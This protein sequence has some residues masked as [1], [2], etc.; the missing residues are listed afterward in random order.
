MPRISFPRLPHL[1]VPG[2][3]IYESPAGEYSTLTS[4]TGGG[5]DRALRGGGR[6]HFDAAGRHT[7]TEDANGNRTTFVYDGA[8]ERVK[9][10][11]IEATGV[12]WRFH[13]DAGGVLDSIV[14]PA[15]RVASFDKSTGGRIIRLYHPD[16]SS[17]RLSYAS[18]RYVPA[19]VANEVD[20]AD[21]IYYDGLSRPYRVRRPYNS[22]SLSP[23][24]PNVYVRSAT[25]EGVSMGNGSPAGAI[26]AQ[27]L[28]A[29]A[30]TFTDPRNNATVFRTNVFGEPTYV[31]DALGRET[32]ILRN[33]SSEPYRVQYPNGRVVRLFWDEGRLMQFWDSTYATNH[34]LPGE[35]K[36]DFYYEDPNCPH[37]LTRVVRWTSAT[38]SLTSTYGYDAGVDPFDGCRLASATDERGHVTEFSYLSDGRV[39]RVTEKAIPA[40]IGRSRDGTTQFFYYSASHTNAGSRGNLD[41]LVTIHP[42]YTAGRTFW[43]G[44]TV[45]PQDSLVATH[46]GYD[47]YGNADYQRDPEGHEVW[48][49]FDAMNQPREVAVEA[50]ASS[51]SFDIIHAFN[52]D[53]AGR[54]TH[55]YQ[56]YY[57]MDGPDSTI[58][59]RFEYS[60]LGLLFRE[61]SESRDTTMYL[62]DVA[63]NVQRKRSGNGHSSDFQH[64]ALNRVWREVISESTQ[65]Y[66]S[67]GLTG[68]IPTRTLPA[69]TVTWHYDVSGQVDT[70]TNR[71]GYVIRD[72][73]LDGSPRTERQSIAGTEHT[74]SYEYDLLGRRT[75]LNH[76]VSLKNQF[77][78]RETHYIYIRPQNQSCP[79]RDRLSLFRQALGELPR[80]YDV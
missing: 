68:I 17:W 65:P 11:M 73:Y 58:S 62:Y 77:G 45:Q 18:G 40:A 55:V 80:R 50:D 3:G 26:Q 12:K 48:R 59:R 47:S 33:G 76:P 64:D 67:E 16:N 66:A 74:L 36:T 14:D 9:E 60:S 21:S 61:I 71:H 6:V 15:G 32:N 44:W 19:G 1:R 2:G 78:T 72:Y 46:L 41:S 75:T 52:Y 53:A 56:P 31:R 28:D 8:V 63:G 4:A 34:G 69:N 13:Y 10:I 43:D 27:R 5:W 79:V 39:E 49:V 35:A 51:D 24:Y 38:Q 70:V 54:R 23:S 25:V 29:I 42:G 7:F 57:R 20:N 22:A 37:D 30:D